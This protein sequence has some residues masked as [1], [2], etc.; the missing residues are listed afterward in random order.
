MQKN[1]KVDKRALKEALKQSSKYDAAK[2]HLKSLSKKS[3]TPSTTIARTTKA[4][5][6]TPKQLAKGVTAKGAGKVASR[7]IPVIGE[8]LMTYDVLKE[9]VKRIAKGIKTGVPQ[10]KLTGKH[11]KDTFKRVKNKKYTK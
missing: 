8:A 10:T 11:I 1:I 5:S 2:K 3:K 9:G 4:F 7:A 6:A